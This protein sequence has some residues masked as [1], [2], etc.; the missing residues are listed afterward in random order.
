MSLSSKEIREVVEELQPLVGGTVQKVW[1]PTPR[2]A[3][4]ELRVPGETHLLLLSAEPNETRIHRATQRPPSPSNPFA[5]QGLLRAH[6]LPSRIVAIRA[7]E[8]ERVVRVEFETRD[9]PRS[10]VGELTG[11]H[12]NLVLVDGEERI[13]GVAV[14]SR[15][16]TRTIRQGEI[17]LPPPPTE[18]KER[19]SRF[20]EGQGGSFAVSRAIEESYLPLER[21]REG[22]ELRR[23]AAR[24]LANAKKRHSNALR[25][26]EEESQRARKAED[27]RQYGELLK[28][29][30]G[31]IAKGAKE[32]TALSY[33]E[34]G[35]VEVRIPLRPE[36]SPKENLDRIFK[37]Y[38]RMLVAGERIRT[39]REELRASLE[40]VEALA[41]RL[42]ETGAPG[43]LEDLSRE[44]R[45]LESAR[46]GEASRTA[47][48]E[49]RMPYRVFTTAA[50]RP[51]W[52][53][54]G[55]KENDLL[56]FR[57]ARGTDV[58]FH[59]RGRPGAHV[60]LPMER[61]ASPD[62]EDLLDACALAA[63]FSGAAKEAV[64]EIAWTHVRH[65]KK[66]K[67]AAAG[68]V[69]M[70]GERTIPYRFDERRLRRLFDER[71]PDTRS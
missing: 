57:H 24:I 23:D 54:R 66:P 50:G 8:G 49:I 17:L 1:T 34:E 65:V 35:T 19:A 62:P 21:E 4:L 58:W 27:L 31:R 68:A 7:L 36:L 44:V 63:H 28:P 67:G 25:K 61:G 51:I 5:F 18:R 13:L 48:R 52:V 6:L 16:S 47:P 29:L 43:A 41:R 70:T 53:G 26:L 9:G 37:D 30:L 45:A 59:A 42:E 71:D 15:S 64:A 40:R 2:V 55:A 60:I 69:V 11:R 12:G 22:R 20:A 14:Y 56:T 39:R 33:G 32:V 10:L 3:V 38:R 46:R